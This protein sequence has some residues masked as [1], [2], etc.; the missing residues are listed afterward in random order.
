M[1]APTRA[2]DKPSPPGRPPPRPDPAAPASAAVP[3]AATR[4]APRPAA[5]SPCPARRCQ[6]SPSTAHAQCPVRRASRS[7]PLLRRA[8]PASPPHSPPQAATAIGPGPGLPGPRRS[9]HPS[10]TAHQLPWSASG[11]ARL[12]R[13]HAERPVPSA[14]VNTHRTTPRPS[15]DAG[16]SGQLFTCPRARQGWA[17]TRSPQDARTQG[18]ASLGR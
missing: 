3:A 11:R 16:W 12:V 18:T 17:R 5:P 1:P 13:G 10:P 14:R 4:T 6:R 8:P 9:R 2:Y 15:K 7:A